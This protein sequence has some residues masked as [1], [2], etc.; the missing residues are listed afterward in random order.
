[1]S[2]ENVEIVRRWIGLSNAGDLPAIFELLDPD[3]E[4]FPAEGEPE[5]APFRGRAAYMERA[6][7]AREAFDEHR[8]EVSEYIDL[9]EYVAVVARIDARGRASRARVS[10][11]EVWLLR[12]KDGKC[13]EYRECGTKERALEA[14]GGS[15]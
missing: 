5:A 11:D 9:G 3:I 15:E 2:Q 12:F 7:D 6:T 1:M 10:G 8:I 14:A 13:V 4:C